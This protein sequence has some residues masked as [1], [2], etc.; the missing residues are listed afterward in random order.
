[1]IYYTQL[2]YIKEGKQDLFEAF[3]NTVLPL[4]EKYDG[5]LLLRIRPAADA[6]LASSVE[7]PY[8]VHLVSFPAKINFDSYMSDESRKLALPLKD[9]SVLRVVLI[10]GHAG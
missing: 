5:Q 7:P 1:M 3:E 8:E 10:E 9:Q 4:L 6:V 2:I